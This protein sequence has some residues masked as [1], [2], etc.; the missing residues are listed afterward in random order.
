MFDTM[1]R[2]LGET[3]KGPSIGLGCFRASKT[4]SE[5]KARELHKIGQR[6]IGS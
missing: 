2:Q 1:E 4:K 3:T 6:H 5:I